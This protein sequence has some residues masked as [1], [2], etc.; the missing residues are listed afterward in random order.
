LAGLTQILLAIF[1]TF[2][3]WL[4]LSNSLS[5]ALLNLVDICRPISG[6]SGGADGALDCGTWR[7]IRD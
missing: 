1:E 5:L 4:A 6:G 2:Q 3:I 7:A